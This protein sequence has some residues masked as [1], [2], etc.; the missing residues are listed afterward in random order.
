MRVRMPGRRK[1]I[2]AQITSSVAAPNR[3]RQNTTS[4]TACPESMTSQPMVPEMSMAAT[5]SIEP[6]CID[7]SMMGL[8][9]M[10]HSMTSRIRATPSS[11]KGENYDLPL[12][13][14]HLPRFT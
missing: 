13:S 4:S 10:G 1:P 8:L 2:S 12:L 14:R 3:Q 9:C 6:R 5:I 7:L 11:S